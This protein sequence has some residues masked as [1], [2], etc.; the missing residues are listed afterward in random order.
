M[1]SIRYG[2]RYVARSDCQDLQ[3]ALTNM[4]M[5]LCSLV[6]GAGGGAWQRMPT[7]AC[8]AWCQVACIQVPSAVS[9]CRIACI[10]PGS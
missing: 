9:P 8:M 6:C 10:R 5:C 2:R 3:Q 1:S 4:S 7:A